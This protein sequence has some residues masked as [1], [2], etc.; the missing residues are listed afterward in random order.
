M[1]AEKRFITREKLEEAERFRSLGLTASLEKSA[2]MT[3]FVNF[4]DLDDLMNLT[5]EEQKRFLEALRIHALSKQSL[6]MMKW[7][8]PSTAELLKQVRD[9]IVETY[10]SRQVRELAEKYDKNEKD[11]PYDF[12]AAY[13]LDRIKYLIDLATFTGNTE[14]LAKAIARMDE[15]ARLQSTDAPTETLI[16]FSSAL[17]Y[18]QQ[19]RERGPFVSL[20]DAYKQAISASSMVKNWEQVATISSRYTLESARSFRPIQTMRGMWNTFR[21]FLHRP[22]TATIFPRE[23]LKSL[24]G[25][26]KRW[27]WKKTTPKESNYARDLDLPVNS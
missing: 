25:R 18:R 6:A 5:P 9:T 21:S 3:S 4:E 13:E 23:A 16:R 20:Q 12:G 26:M 24:G 10:N 2:Q 17:L 19:K 15:L 22:T 1:T 8:A 27:F 14:I 11:S 7:D